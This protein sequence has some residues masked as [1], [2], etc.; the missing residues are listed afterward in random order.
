MSYAE[1]ERDLRN[2]LSDNLAG[3]PRQS[4][5]TAGQAVDKVQPVIADVQETL[6]QTRAFAVRVMELADRLCGSS[7]G[8]AGDCG[9]AKIPTGD[10]QKLRANMRDTRQAFVFADEALNRIERE[11][12]G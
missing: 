8:A 4:N 3:G 5:R 12:I 9:D 1:M 10:F 2:T 7:V 11:L 6:E